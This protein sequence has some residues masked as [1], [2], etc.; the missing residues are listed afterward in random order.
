[1]ISFNVRVDALVQLHLEEKWRMPPYNS[2]QMVRTRLSMVRDTSQLL[3]KRF[4]AGDAQVQPL[5]SS[6]HSF[7]PF[8]LNKLSESM[9]V[10]LITAELIFAYL[11]QGLLPCRSVCRVFTPQMQNHRW[12]LIDHLLVL[13]QIPEYV[14][15]VPPSDQPR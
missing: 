12:S 1:M 7:C 8:V 15:V 14:L 13:G 3:K 11:F 5:R 9:R 6:L 2:W 10:S 4:K